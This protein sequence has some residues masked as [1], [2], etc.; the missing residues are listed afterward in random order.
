LNIPAGVED[1][2]RLQLNGQGE[3]GFAGGPSGDLY[4]DMAVKKHDTF[5]RDGDNLTCT[6]EVPLHDAVL[7]ALA[8]IKT[9]DGEA[10]IEIA[11]GQQTNDTVTLKGKGVTHLR[12]AGR[13]DLVVTIQVLTPTK[14]DSKQ[15][16]LFRS[17][18]KLRK[19]DAIR[20][21]QHSS[22]FFAGKR[23]G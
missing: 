22:G 7:G 23:K 4:V 21:V 9:F 17:L 2:L 11:P 1:G 5:G 20:L 8:K 14:L 15:K 16:E 10:E 13:G 3:V 18:A 12:S 19:S 6:V